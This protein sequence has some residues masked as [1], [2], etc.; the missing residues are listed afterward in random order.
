[1][2]K[3][4][5]ALLCALSVFLSLSPP[6]RAAEVCF[7]AINITVL[8]LTS[9]T[10]PVWVG[11]T[12][13]VPY[14]VFNA[15]STGVSLG[16]SSTYSRDRDTVSVFSISD[17]LIFDLND[18]TCRNQHSGETLSGQAII[19]NGRPYLP[20]ALVCS[21]FGLN[22][23]SYFP[24]SYGYVVRIS[25]KNQSLS[26]STFADAGSE[27][28]RIRLRDYNQ[29]LNPAPTEETAE[30]APSE[31]APPPAQPSQNPQDPQT[32]EEPEIPVC[33]AFRCDTGQAIPE[34]LDA[35]D[36]Q[37]AAGLF[38]LRPEDIAARGDLVRRILGTGHS[39]GI[40]TEAESVE[41]TQLL[42][43]QGQQALETVAHARTYYALTGRTEGAPEEQ[44]GWRSW[45][46]GVAVTPDGSASAYTLAQQAV[47]ALPRNVDLA[48][49]LLD[50]SRDT[51]DAMTFLLRQ[52]GE[53]QYTVT[54]PRE[55]LL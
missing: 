39:V 24:T 28:L 8:P 43:D 44:T 9:D 53:R 17:M 19:R 27:V 47:R 2:K 23:P 55:T 21:F 46:G 14:T 4:I 26:D 49:L 20:A 37:G 50:D 25:D 12:L 36:R 10:M 42:L 40:L 11:G 33:L 35:L 51:A 3:R 48:L 16:T 1:M 38:Y 54:V 5:L 41:E 6:S 29:S 13:Y 45:N 15:G 31:P 34:I 52:L 30:P 7:T 18:N 32:Q 22:P